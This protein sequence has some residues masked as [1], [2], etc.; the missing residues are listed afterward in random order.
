MR[1]MALVFLWGVC[2]EHYICLMCTCEMNLVVRACLERLLDLV[3]VMLSDE[4]VGA[5]NA[6]GFRFD[7]EKGVF[8]SKAY[9]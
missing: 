4:K 1:Y 5:L 9:F 3:A 6:S 2:V 8:F 7:A